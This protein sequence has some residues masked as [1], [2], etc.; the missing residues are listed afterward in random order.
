MHTKVVPETIHYIKFIKTYFQSLVRI[1]YLYH[2]LVWKHLKK[3]FLQL[4]QHI[5]LLADQ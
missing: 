2:S 4:E 5:E 3:Y 1:C